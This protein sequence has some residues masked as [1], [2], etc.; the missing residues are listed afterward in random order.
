MKN[1]SVF[2][3]IALLLLSLSSHASAMLYQDGKTD[4]N[5][6]LSS[7]ST[8]AEKNAAKEFQK[9]WKLATGNE[10]A[11]TNKYT[12]GKQILI[13][14]SREAQQL[15]PEI[16]LGSLKNDEIIIAPVGD[17]LIL[18]GERPRGTLY[19]VYEF[20]KREMG[21][22]FWTAEDE[23]VPR[24]V[25]IAMPDQLFR[26][27]PSVKV[28]L[29]YFRAILENPDFAAK[30]HCFGPNYTSAPEWG[31]EY[32]NLIGPWHT[33]D[34]FLPAS[35][36][37]ES[38]PE[39]FSLRDGKRLGGQ[40][41]GQLC[42]SNPA[43]RQKFLEIVR[44]QLK[45]NP[46]AKVISVSQNDNDNYCQCTECARIDKNGNSPSASIITFVNFIAEHIEKE[47]PD[48]E[49]QT[50]AYQY[51]RT[52]PAGIVP[53]KNVSILLCAIE[54]DFSK[55]LQTSGNPDNTA[56]LKD[57][58]AW[59]K[60]GAK[61]AIWYYI[62]NFNNFLLPHPNLESIKKDVGF[63]GKYSPSMFLLECDAANVNP[64]DDLLPLKTWIGAQLLWNPSLDPEKLEDEFLSGYY[65]KAAPLIKKYLTVRKTDTLKNTESVGCF[66]YTAK[67]V[68]AD[69]LFHCLQILN[70]AQKSV[71]GDPIL[72]DRISMLAKPF[73]YLLISDYSRWQTE[74][75]CPA[76]PEAVRI[77][78]NYLDFLARKKVTHIASTNEIGATKRQFE[79]FIN[80]PPVKK[81]EHPFL[82]RFKNRRLLV[83][84]EDAF[85]IHGETHAQVVRDEKAGN[86]WAIMLKH[87]GTS[88]A[89]QL[90]IRP[91]F[92][93]EKSYE[94]YAACRLDRKAKH[95][96]FQFGGYDLKN[97]ELYL[98]VH[99]DADTL[100][101]EQYTY[102]PLGT[103]R[104][105]E[106]S[107]LFLDSKVN[108]EIQCSYVDHLLFVEK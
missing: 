90:P 2:A 76:D 65:G 33:F 16:D 47:F 78:K 55:P 88:W 29:P 36:Y 71:E 83:F 45:N 42:L 107:Y 49:I 34:R 18:C 58:A 95:G 72:T 24:S 1:P 26:Y 82:A 80:Y 50:F 105:R 86:N 22:R 43:L 7:E 98:S 101:V 61:L 63:L 84:E 56:F 94:V 74:K 87:I 92:N 30:M 14:Q 10:L 40:F 100:G 68:S 51:S 52:P 81:K 53:R 32:V 96:L 59:Q 67:W 85:I 39:Y 20:L 44:A 21:I 23:S 106:K 3:L 108:P 48:V 54:A 89:V 62:S 102:I 12:G 25:A 8:L 103:Y 41:Q 77:A 13:G 35:E 37:L 31:G 73:E 57:L 38:N 64:I 66:E 15:L 69:L 19:A 28:R 70:E 91:E 17:L 4:Y 46:N 97:R 27:T 79:R 5:I 99:P 6:Y 75:K 11:V 9:Y 60:T 93:L 104:F